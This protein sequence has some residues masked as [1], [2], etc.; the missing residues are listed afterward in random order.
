MR[1]LHECANARACVDARA[2]VRACVRAMA[3]GSHEDKHS[4]KPKERVGHAQRFGLRVRRVE[5]EAAAAATNNVA[6]QRNVA[7]RR[8][9]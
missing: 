7:T 4:G 5:R 6:T 2:R 3:G 9:T 1:A 8:D